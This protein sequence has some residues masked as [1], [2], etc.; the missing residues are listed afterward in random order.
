MPPFS[1]KTLKYQFIRVV[2][3]WQLDETYVKMN[4]K[5]F[6]LYRA[7]DKYGDTLDVYFSPKRNRHSSYEFLKRVLKPYP[8]E[9]QPK[10]LNTDKHEAYGY[11]IA[12]LIKKG[13]LRADAKQRQVKTLNNRIESEH[14]P[15]KK[16][17]VAAGGFKSA[18]R[19]WSTLQG[20]ET[21]RKLNKGQFDEWLRRYEPECRVRERSAFINQLFNVETVLA[22]NIQ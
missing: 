3:S 2:S 1:V 20:F 9:R 5:W 17:I 21:L 6:Y 14:T 11:A 10:I 4:G 15:I 12:R 22:R 18:K 13:K 8:S 19:A 7:I 16:L